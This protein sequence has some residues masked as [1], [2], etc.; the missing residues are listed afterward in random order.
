MR[1]IL[2][3]N[4]RFLGGDEIEEL[5][6]PVLIFLELGYFCLGSGRRL[7]TCDLPVDLRE[8]EVEQFFNILDSLPRL[9]CH[10][11]NVL[12]AWNLGSAGGGVHRFLNFGY[13]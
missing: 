3:I 10:V 1:Y 6:Y 8:S 7:K 12:G 5:L 13:E 11:L 4:G 9:G 2:P